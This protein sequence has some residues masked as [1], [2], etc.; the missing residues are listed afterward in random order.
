M[1]NK[2][3]W[4][5]Y[6]IGLGVCLGLRLI[7]GRPP[8]VEPILAAAMPFAKRYGYAPGFA[9]GF[10]SIAFFDLITGQ[11]GEWTF[12]TAAAYGLVGFGAAAFLKKRPSSAWNYFLYS[13]VGT[14]AYDALT[15]LT[16]GPL[17]FRQPFYAALLGQIPFTLLHL[18]GSCALAFLISPSLYRWVVLSRKLNFWRNQSETKVYT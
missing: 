8:N 10:L 16:I 6:C 3:S 11:L 15:G 2:E 5:K 4:L 14:L 13:I 9:F 7:P 17:F 12:V 1:K 18:L